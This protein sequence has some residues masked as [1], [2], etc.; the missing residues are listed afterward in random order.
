MT[1]IKEINEENDKKKNI[2][3]SN[4]KK[5]FEKD[6]DNCNIPNAEDKVEF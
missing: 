3:F 1:I 2:G 5:I 6:D 4:L